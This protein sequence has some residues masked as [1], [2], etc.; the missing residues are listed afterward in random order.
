MFIRIATGRD[1]GEVKEFDF[2]VAQGMLKRGDAYR[3]DFD[4]PNWQDKMTDEQLQLLQRPHLVERQ[5]ET[6]PALVAAHQPAA[7]G[8]RTVTRS[9]GRRR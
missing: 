8:Q 7:I 6:E 2:E 4:H 9:T 3:V 1:R 5:T